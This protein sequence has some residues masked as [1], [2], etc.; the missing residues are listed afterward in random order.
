MPDATQLT[1]TNSCSPAGDKLVAHTR[2]IPTTTSLIIAEHTAVQHKNI[3][4]L[5]RE[6][7][8]DF[9]EFGTVT[10]ET[11]VAGQSPNPTKYAI[12]NE[13]Q[14]YLLIT[15]LRN[16][17]IVRAFKKRLIHAFSALR[18]PRLGDALDELDTALDRTRQAIEIARTERTR[19]DKAEKKLEAEQRHRAAIEAGDGID[20][21]TFGKKYFSEVRKTDFEKHLYK[22]GYLIDQRGT[23]QRPDGTLAD[24]YDHRMPTAKGREYIYAHDGGTYGGRRRLTPRVR[25]QAEI[26]LRD[27]LAAE[28]LPVNEHSTGLILLT[29]DDMKTLTS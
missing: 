13:D 17:Q 29:G 21:T 14:A 7:S 19:A 4:S 22:H 15:Y 26:A 24:G 9:E 10:F 1:E 20:L 25:P 18:S 8:A 16:S 12:L 11:R 2:G 27:R 23:R 3:L 5:I 6:H 28:G